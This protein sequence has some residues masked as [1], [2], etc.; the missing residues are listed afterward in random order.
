MDILVTTQNEDKGSIRSLYEKSFTDSKAFVDYYFEEKFVPERTMAIKEDHKI[1]S[2]LHLNPFKVQYNCQVNEISY[3]VAVAT[4]INYRKQGHMGTL[5]EAALN[6]LYHEKETFCLLMPIDSRIYERYGF[7]FVED[8]LRFDI[9]SAT[10]TVESTDYSCWTLT[11][12]DIPR[13]VAL[14]NDYSKQFNL[15]TIRDNKEFTKL[16]HELN[17]DSGEIIVFNEGYMMTYYEHHVLNIREF[18]YTSEKAFKE[19]ISY[20]KDKTSMGRVVIADHIRSSIKYYTPNISENTI[21]LIPFMMARI[22]HVELFLRRNL[23]LFKQD[24]RIKVNDP[25]ISENNRIFY[26]HEDNIDIFFD[27][28]YDIE[29]DIKQLSQIVFGY[30]KATELNLM[31][32]IKKELNSVN[33]FNEFV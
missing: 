8:H 22:I 4:D 3:I 6:R 1:I 2:M 9:N 26:I 15:A 28:H 25:Y 11:P 14:Y 10:L 7:G 24:I 16:Y 23:S 12:N 20:I 18:V 21:K 5:M 30:I 19:M 33:F 17:T 13:I 32:F 27:G 31:N 29:L